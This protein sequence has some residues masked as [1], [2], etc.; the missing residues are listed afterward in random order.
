MGGVSI[1]IWF[2]DFCDVEWYYGYDNF[3]MICCDCGIYLGGCWEIYEKYDC[4][5]GVCF[6]FFYI[7]DCGSDVC[8]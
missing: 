6:C 2:N 3:V 4:L 7:S 1:N 8:Y 5:D